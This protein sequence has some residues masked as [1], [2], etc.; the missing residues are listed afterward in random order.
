MGPTSIK[1]AY[2]Y[3]C[4]KRAFRSGFCWLRDRTIRSNEILSCMFDDS[5]FINEAPLKEGQIVNSWD[6]F[7]KD[8]KDTIKKTVDPLNYCD[9]FCDF[10]KKVDRTGQGALIKQLFGSEEAYVDSPGDFHRDQD[11][12]EHSI[13][14]NFE[15]NCREGNLLQL[16]GFWCNHLKKCHEWTYPKR[17]R[18]PLKLRE[19][20][21]SYPQT[22]RETEE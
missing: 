3:A 1:N 19:M 11:H 13:I 18:T 2:C 8:Y 7:Y 10:L 17:L 4:N 21:G 12:Y 6:A 9:A 5:L 22:V 15:A 16:F 14:Y 20:R